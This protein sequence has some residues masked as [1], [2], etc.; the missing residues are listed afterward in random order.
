LLNDLVAVIVGVFA[1]VLQIKIYQ[2]LMLVAFK[3]TVL[4]DSLVFGA[5]TRLGHLLPVY[6]LVF[7]LLV[8]I[9]HQ[10]AELISAAINVNET[11]SY[12]KFIWNY[13][14]AVV[15]GLIIMELFY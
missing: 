12:M 13:G 3:S 4:P 7:G 8:I 5:L 2:T 9:F 10:I 1:G 6:A 11:R 15:A 14:P